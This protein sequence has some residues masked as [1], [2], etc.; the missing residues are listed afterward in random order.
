MSTRLPAKALRPIFGISSIQRCLINTLAIGRSQT[1]VLATSTNSEDDPLVDHTVNGRADVV[2]GS[3]ADVLQRFLAAIDRHKADIVIRVTGDCPSISYEIAN[4]LLE[5]HLRSDADLTY[6][7][8]GFPIGTGCEVYNARAL[9]RLR[10]LLPETPYSEYLVLYFLNNPS[11]FKINPI[12]LPSFYLR[13]WRLTLDE[14]SDLDLFEYMFSELNIGWRAV[15]FP[16]IV[17]FFEKFPEAANI[18]IA[19]KLRY[20]HDIDFVKHLKEVTTIQV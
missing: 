14:Q 10:L 15:S 18:N 13:N 5:A 7:V 19:N 12:D 17:S 6:A 4:I 16:E 9:E 8:P 11:Y 20:I 3:E 2:R 1:S